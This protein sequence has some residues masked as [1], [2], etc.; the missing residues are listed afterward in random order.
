MYSCS[1]EVTNAPEILTGRVKWFNNKTGFGF[2][3]VTDGSN[4]GTDIF[5]HHS[6]INVLSE[7]YKYLVQ[8]E[9][10]EFTLC[11]TP[12]GK[13]KFQAG[14]VKG[15]KGGQ[16]MCETRREFKVARNNFK[17]EKFEITIKDE[18]DNQGLRQ[19]QSQGQGLQQS[20]RQSQGP[21]HLRTE[22]ARQRKNENESQGEWS[23]VVK[24]GIKSAAVNE[25][26]SKPLLLPVK[27]GRKPK[28]V[29]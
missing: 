10:V 29:K 27:R 13:H 20:Q 1:I 5:V 26:E 12:E 25:S 15:I 7:Q 11:D 6:S 28:E 23:R 19:S 22:G 16:L 24:K 4:V 17:E 3:T 21:R 14:N 2:I 8:G 18:S 9:Y